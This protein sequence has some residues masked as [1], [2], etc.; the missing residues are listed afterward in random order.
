MKS[1]FL[2]WLAAAVLLFLTSCLSVREEFWFE[3]NGSGRIEAEYQLPAI[4]I[5]SLGGEEKLKSIIEDLLKKHPGV[6]LEHYSIE[7][8]GAQAALKIHVHFDSVLQLSKLLD[9][10]ADGSETEPL[11]D[12]MLKLLGDIKVKREGIAV[13][14]QRSIDPSSL[15]GGGF[16]SPGREQ[17]KDYQLEYI[18]H[19]PTKATQTNAHEIRDD[20]YT[21]AWR[22]ELADAIQKPVTTNFVTP[23]PIPIWLWL[24]LAAVIGLLVWR[25]LV[26]RRKILRRRTA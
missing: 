18:M 2:R 21:L 1:V 14:Y 20:G 16:L 9:K 26:I 8:K 13:D 10:P 11:P 15:F 4:A 6:T 25:A 22:Y 17:L 19:L 12:P 23:I 3:R 7:K 5:A 24:A